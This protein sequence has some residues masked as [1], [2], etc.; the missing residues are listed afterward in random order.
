MSLKKNLIYTM[1]LIIPLIILMTYLKWSQLALL[2]IALT[3]GG[4]SLMMFIIAWCLKW[5]AERI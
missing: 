3:L 1:M 5:Y 4:I 2:I